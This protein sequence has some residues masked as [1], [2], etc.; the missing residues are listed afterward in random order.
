MLNRWFSPQAARSGA[1][2]LEAAGIPVTVYPADL[3]ERGLEAKATSQAAGAI[4][5]LLAREKAL[6]VDG[7]H[8]GRVIQAAA[9]VLSLH[10]ETRFA[11]PA[12]PAVAQGRSFGTL[13]G[14]TQKLCSAI[15]FVQNTTVS[16]SLSMSAPPD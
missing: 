12:D 5:A 11:K 6:A 16:R 2:L 3:D 8:R 15:V 4:A 7:L 1:R 14:R 13:S 9:Q 10:G